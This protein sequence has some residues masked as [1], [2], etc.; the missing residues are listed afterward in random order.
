MPGP[1]YFAYVDEGVAFNAVTHAVEDEPIF[2]LEIAQSEG[3]F[4][5]LTIEV[6][7]PTVGLLSAGRK[8]W[9]WLSHDFGSGPVALFNGRLVGVPQRLADEVVALQFVARPIDYVA[10]QTALADALK[11]LP[12]Y[13]PVW[14]QDRLDDPNAALEARTLLWD[15]NRTSLVVTTT[16][17]I[18]GEAGTIAVGE[19]G[20]LYDEFDVSY[21]G[22]PLRRIAVTGTVS[23]SQA[24][25]GEIDLTHELVAA[26]QAAGSPTIYPMVSSL[27]GPGLLQSWPKPGAAIGSGTGWK[28]ADDAAF[29]EVTYIHSPLQTWVYTKPHYQDVT[30][31]NMPGKFVHKPSPL[32]G[33]LV[34][35]PAKTTP[36]KV[37]SGYD[38]YALIVPLGIFIPDFR[39][40]WE[41]ARR[42]GETVSFTLEADIQ[43]L[44]VDAGAAETETLA[45]NSAVVD[46]PVD[47][48]GALP[49]GNPLAAGYFK[50]DRGAR[51][52]EFLLLVARARLLASARAVRLKLTMPWNAAITAISCRHNITVTDRRL[53][54]PATGKVVQYS[55]RAT[56]DGEMVAKATLGCT[57]GKGEALGAAAGGTPVYAEDGIL[58]DGIQA[59]TGG[60]V[61]LLPGVLLY[62][63]VD[64]FTLTDDGLDLL[65][66]TAS[67]FLTSLTVT[68]GPDGQRAAIAAAV[69]KASPTPQPASPRMGVTILYGDVGQHGESEPSTVL[70]NHPTRVALELVPIGKQ[71]FAAT[72]TPTVSQLVIPKTIDLEAA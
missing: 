41:A 14:L 70:G 19:S 4:A 26:F 51:S 13:D 40:S 67:S 9:C 23:W 48:G 56:G 57:I 7:N 11:V 2:S 71:S 22:T 44:L 63:S 47:D 52:I 35:Q 66:V 34:W 32:G 15:T 50:R 16:D 61:A 39:V 68:D 64:N 21:S 20:H 58:E 49:I 62:E 5:T 69:Q 59:R 36:G 8:I 54:E 31:L 27:T 53:A 29:D 37:I 3:D 17:I 10:Q 45:L 33:G 6:P 43:P 65:N 38:K 18:A 24:G 25:G 1:F 46:Q 55:L 42:R 12:Y 30:V 60:E 72:F 28:L